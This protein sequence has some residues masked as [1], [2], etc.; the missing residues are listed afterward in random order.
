MRN[1]W[2]IP[3]FAELLFGL[4]AAWAAGPV[5]Q[6]YEVIAETGVLHLEE[7]LRYA[8]R[9]ER[10]CMD[11]RQLMTSFWMLGH[12]SLQ[13]CELVRVSE[14]AEVVLLKLECS[15][16]H[17]TMGSARWQFSSNRAYGT[18][19]VRLGGKNM[20]FYQRITAKRLGKCA[21]AAH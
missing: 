15:G 14:D 21:I 9:V 5:P 17:G 18:L 11:E 8:T 6:M 13:D 3:I 2:F 10:R 7:N 4:P 19:Q 12:V 20:T 1:R 16:G